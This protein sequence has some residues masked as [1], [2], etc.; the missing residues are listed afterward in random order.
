MRAFKLFREMKDGSI[1]PLFINKTQR[2]DI[3]KWYKAEAHRTKG[4]KFRPGW[5]CTSQPVAPHLSEK[6]RG[7]YE[8]E[9]K[10]YE[11]M[12]RP[13]S[14]GGLWYLANN[15]KVI[16]KVKDESSIRS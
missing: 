2:L 1:A 5:H 13:P 12:K 3:G 16:K 4:Y 8:V 9:I 15:L 14:Q 6:G 7:W 11:D 10:N